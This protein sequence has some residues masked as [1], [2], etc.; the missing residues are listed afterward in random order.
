[1]SADHVETVPAL[2][3]I[4]VVR[5][6]FIGRIPG[7]DVKVEREA[8]L[9]RLEEFHVAARARVGLADRVFITADQVHGS[10]VAVVDARSR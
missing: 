10:E 7:L 4:A 5:H 6:G 8:A 2:S 3:E 1:M 9:A